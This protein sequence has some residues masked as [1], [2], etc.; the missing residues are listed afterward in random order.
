M[1]AFLMKQK[2]KKHFGDSFTWKFYQQNFIFIKTY[3]IFYEM[4]DI[5]SYFV[6]ILL[7]IDF[8]DYI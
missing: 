2:K 5:F 4:I 8:L 7:L 6:D 3:L 1:L